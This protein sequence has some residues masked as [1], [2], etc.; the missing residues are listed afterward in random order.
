MNEI[1]TPGPVPQA[2]LRFNLLAGGLLVVILI[3]LAGLWIMERG[4]RVR[5]ESSMTTMLQQLEQ[6]QKKLMAMGQMLVQEV[7]TPVVNRRGLPT[8]KV[9]WNAREKTVLLLSAEI[10]GKIGFESGDV[11]QITPP[12]GAKEP[13]TRPEEN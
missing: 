6:Q 2:D 1:K 12:V 7:S 3:T 8:T 11:I 9:Q 10:G 4:R 13:T 5:T